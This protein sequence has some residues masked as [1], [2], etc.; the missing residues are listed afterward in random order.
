[1]ESRE[2]VVLVQKNGPIGTVTINNPPLNI[3]D[4][5]VRQRLFS[6]FENLQDTPDIRIVVLQGAG[7]K[8]FSVGSN[9]NEFPLSHGVQGGKKRQSL[10]KSYIISRLKE[11]WW[12]RATDRR[13]YPPLIGPEKVLLA[14]EKPGTLVVRCLPTFS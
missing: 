2:S 6:V 1:M 5:V 3:L 4:L 7:S 9:I 11:S 14:P 10:S 13:P 12:G 8:A